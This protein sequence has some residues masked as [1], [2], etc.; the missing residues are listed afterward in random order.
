MGGKQT[1]PVMPRGVAVHGKSLRLTFSYKGQ[2]CRE[3]LG[4]PPTKTN[5]KFAAGKLAAIRHEI[6]TGVFVYSAHFPESKNGLLFSAR[7]QR[8]GVRVGDLCEEFKAMKYISIKKATRRRY[9]VG[10]TQCLN[11]LGRE[12]LMDAIYP[13]DIMRIRAELMS[14]RAAST[15]NH[16]M[17]VFREFLEFAHQ[18]DYT[19]R[20]LA[21]ELK[22]VR[23]N[24][25]DPDPLLLEEFQRAAD[26]CLQEQHRNIITVMVYTGL[27]PGELAALAW[28]DVDFKR[29]EITVRRALSDGNFKL[30]KTNKSRVVLLPPPAVAALKNQQQY[31]A[32]QE[33]IE[34][35][36]NIN[37]KEREFSFIRPVFTPGTTANGRR[38]GDFLHSNSLPKIWQQICRRA[39]IRH[40]TVYQLRHTF[41]CWNLTAHGNVAFIARQMG[42]ADYTMLV[43][44]YGRW[45][46]DESAAE[47]AR[48]WDALKSKGHDENAPMLPQQLKVIG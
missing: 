19:N 12:R 22:P 1:D 38:H 24:S 23:R 7:S 29:A 45:M 46:E 17:S 9:N 14:T 2:R 13:E 35:V 36:V 37:N 48:I 40:R 41:A 39:G 32:M 43:K 47:N 5:V 16:Y 34:I 20:P 4:L 27:R 10:Y 42:H 18:N 26:A 31:T 30:P 25:K 11:I 21:A 44:V 28:E 15:C 3:S 8:T 6:K 33:P